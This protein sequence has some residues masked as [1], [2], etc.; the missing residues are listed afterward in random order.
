MIVDE[1]AAGWATV[2]CNHPTEGEFRA[3]LS[4]LPCLREDA[5][6]GVTR[7]MPGVPGDNPTGNKFTVSVNAPGDFVSMA[8]FAVKTAALQHGVQVTG[9]TDGATE[10]KERRCQN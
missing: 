6:V 1:N 7:T 10:C 4:A 8:E 5:G 3:T 2:H 9:V